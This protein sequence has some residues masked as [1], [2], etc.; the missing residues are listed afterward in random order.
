[1][2]G[3]FQ[4]RYTGRGRIMINGPSQFKGDDNNTRLLRNEYYSQLHDQLHTP[5]PPLWG[6][7]RDFKSGTRISLLRNEPALYIINLIRQYLEDKIT[8]FTG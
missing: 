3:F 1:M 2:D 8:L 4:G 5:P 7:L 6:A